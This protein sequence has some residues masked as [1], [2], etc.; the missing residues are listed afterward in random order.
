MDPCSI[1]KALPQDIF[2]KKKKKHLL[3]LVGK[4][5]KSCPQLH[6]SCPLWRFFSQPRSSASTCLVELN[7]G[8]TFRHAVLK[9]HLSPYLAHKPHD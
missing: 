5:S 1:N 7:L 9:R 6:Q 2:F 4:L 8:V 3:S